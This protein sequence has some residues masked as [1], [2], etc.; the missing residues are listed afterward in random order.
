VTSAISASSVLVRSWPLTNVKSIR[1]RAG[2]P[3]AAAMREAN[4]SVG[5]LSIMV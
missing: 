5:T 2:V 1:A 3:M 4:R